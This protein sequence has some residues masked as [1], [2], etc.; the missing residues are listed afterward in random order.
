MGDLDRLIGDL[1]Q[2]G[3]PAPRHVAPRRR[4]APAGLLPL[5]LAAALLAFAGP[6]LALVILAVMAAVGIAV[7][8]SVFAIGVALGPFL[9]V[10]LL[11]MLALRRSRRPPRRMHWRYD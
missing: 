4:Q 3:R 11:V 2:P 8:V 6:G 1:P 7:M 9:I 5:G 10:A